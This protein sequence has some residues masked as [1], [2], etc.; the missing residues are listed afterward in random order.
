MKKGFGYW[1]FLI[2]TVM[3][4]SLIISFSTIDLRYRSIRRLDLAGLQAFY[5]SESAALYAQK[6]KNLPQ[7]NIAGLDLESLKKAPGLERHFNHGGF[8]IVEN[9]GTMYF[10][11][12]AGGSLAGAE[13]LKVLQRKGEILSPWY[14]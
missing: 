3:M 14:E 4:L 9:K 5:M 2:F 11:G 10:L 13:G 12:Y 1:Y 8:K 7:N 6:I